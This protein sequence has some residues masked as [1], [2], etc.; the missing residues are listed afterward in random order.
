[1]KK[2]R[3]PFLIGGGSVLIILLCCGLVFLFIDGYYLPYKPCRPLKFPSLEKRPLPKWGETYQYRTNQ[4]LDEIVE[5]FDQKLRPLVLSEEQSLGIGISA[6]KRKQIK[7][8]TYVYQCIS[9]DI[10]D[11]TLEQGCMY[12]KESPEGT[13]IQTR[14]WVFETANPRCDDPSIMP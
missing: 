4:S 11:I 8:G 7:E 5:L 6:W 1:M 9:A 14:L 13:L 12:I 10:N 3:K 2:L